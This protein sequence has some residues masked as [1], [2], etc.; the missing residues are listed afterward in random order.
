M[1]SIVATTIEPTC[2]AAKDS[3]DLPVAYG[4]GLPCSVPTGD[5]GTNPVG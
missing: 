5:S 4:L 2:L 1:P 3:E